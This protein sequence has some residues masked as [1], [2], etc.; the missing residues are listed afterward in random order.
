MI[1]NGLRVTRKQELI[2]QIDFEFRGLLYDHLIL[3]LANRMHRDA[4]VSFRKN[5]YKDLQVLEEM[6]LI[7]RDQL[8]LNRT[9][10]FIYLSEVG[11]ECV[12]ELLEIPVGYVGSGWKRDWGDFAYE[13]QRPPRVS[14]AVIHHH[15]L[16]TEVLLRFERLK[17]LYPE[18]QLDFR[19]NRY[20]SREFEC[21]GE[22][23]RF[24]PD[25]EIV[26]GESKQRFFVEVDRG[27]EYGEKLREKFRS[28]YQMYLQHLKE[29]G[30]RLP[31]GV[32]FIM[33]KETTNGAIR[34]W[35]LVSACFMNEMQEWSTE[36]NLLGGSV[37]E[38]EQIILRQLDLDKAY[39]V[40]NEKM[41][42]YRTADVSFITLQKGQGIEWSDASMSSV[43]ISET[44]THF[45]AYERYQRFETMG[46]ARIHFWWKWYQEAKKKYRDIAK[47]KHFIPILWHPSNGPDSLSF[48]GYD[49]EKEF[50]E[51]FAER[52]W[53]T[54]DPHP[55]WF[56]AAGQPG[57][58]WPSTDPLPSIAQ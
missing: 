18:I 32:I 37:S 53:L 14:S 50:H 5:T 3:E 41:E 25:A 57:K 30:E 39:G 55:K 54:T 2:L 31:A 45:Y 48:K 10:D 4:G 35:A 7:V 27:T 43:K 15:L 6:K 17:N 12:C 23:H 13:L 40:F 9:V 33:N 36:F 49:L 26:I 16:L 21:K 42:H 58:Y 22:K 56:N 1:F 28:S 52:R 19:D 29:K 47:S 44:E 38:I 51:A 20:C 8:K 46:I 24:R 11:L 34:R